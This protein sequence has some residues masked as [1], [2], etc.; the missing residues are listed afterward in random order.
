MVIAL[1]NKG[2]ICH[3]VEI[4]QYDSYHVRQNGNNGKKK[5]WFMEIVYSK[6]LAR[7]IMPGEQI[8]SSK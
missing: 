6:F 1:A 3:K 8:F 5:K 4:H 7:L 2:D